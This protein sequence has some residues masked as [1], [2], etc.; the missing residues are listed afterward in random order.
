M[1]FRLLG[2]LEIRAGDGPIALAAGK[3]RSLVALL[4]LE[5]N[6]NVPRDRIVDA[7]WG[8]H[9]PASSPKMVQILVSQVRRLLPEPRVLTR[10][11]G[12]VLEVRDDEVDLH[13]FERAVAEATR[14][15]AHEPERARFLLAEALGLWRG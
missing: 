7:L 10:S 15:L 12:Y 6:R 5:A 11:P 2:P 4:A 3:Q 8:E 9:A 14:A 1:D 13:R